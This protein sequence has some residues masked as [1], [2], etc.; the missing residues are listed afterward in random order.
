MQKT[1]HLTGLLRRAALFVV[2][3]TLVTWL[4]TGAHWGWTRTSVT[5]MKHDE[6]TGID[7]PVE[8][9]QFIAGVEVLALGAGLGVALGAASFAFARRARPAV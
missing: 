3:A 9:A 5:E 1:S 2:A 7:F 6:I 8:R 4:A